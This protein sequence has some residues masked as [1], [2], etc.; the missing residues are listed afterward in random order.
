MKPNIG[1]ID[2]TL[3][4]LI[5]LAII[6]FGVVNQSWIGA[7]GAIPLLTALIRFCPAYVPLGIRTFGKMDHAKRGNCCDGGSCG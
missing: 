2:R 7:L 5:G 3:R 1:N 6:A 4:V